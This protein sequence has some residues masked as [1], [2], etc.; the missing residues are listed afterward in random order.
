MPATGTRGGRSRHP[1]M[2]MWPRSPG[3]NGQVTA[4]SI[5]TGH[6]AVGARLHALEWSRTAFGAR[7][8][9]STIHSCAMGR[10]AHSPCGPMLRAWSTLSSSRLSSTSPDRLAA[11]AEHTFGDGCAPR[12]G[13]RR[14]AL[15]CARQRRDR[16]GR[17]ARDRDARSPV[18]RPLPQSRGAGHAAVPD[19]AA[20]WLTRDA[21]RLERTTSSVRVT[22]L[23]ARGR[24]A[25]LLFLFLLLPLAGLVQMEA[26]EFEHGHPRT[27]ATTMRL[28]QGERARVHGGPYAR[29]FCRSRRSNRASSQTTRPSTMSGPQTVSW[30]SRRTRGS[31]L[32]RERRRLLRSLRQ[33]GRG[34]GAYHEASLRRGARSRA[35][36]E[37]RSPHA[38]SHD[39]I[40]A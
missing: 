21:P 9:C 37:G 13:P 3:W 20:V 36:A 33:Q 6:G 39:R 30:R 35:D 1:Q 15:L 16:V 27:K 17:Q 12:L 28:H 29:A 31:A 10:S 40:S 24:R 26:Y 32:R 25:G 11:R 34:T 18:A 19:A 38:R 5:A 7:L 4:I 14:R 2:S 22:R 23:P 8:C